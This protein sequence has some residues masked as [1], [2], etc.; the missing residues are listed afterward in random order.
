METTL[1]SA[2]LL[3]FFCR[4]C[5]LDAN[6]RIENLLLGEPWIDDVKDSVDRERSLSDV[7]REDHL[8]CTRRRW[9]ENSSLHFRR[10]SGI[11]WQDDQIRH[12]RPERLHALEQNLA[13]GV[14][15]FLASKKAEDVT[16]ALPPRT[17]EGR[18]IFPWPARGG[19]QAIN[20]VINDKIWAAARK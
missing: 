14:D 8:A 2:H 5:G 4:N 20:F 3:S 11:D 17:P 10:Q 9:L 19:E 15:L 12:V 7:R 13:T 6:P 16:P 1:E 18:A